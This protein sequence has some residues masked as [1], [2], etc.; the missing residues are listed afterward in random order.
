[1]G[2]PR[3]YFVHTFGCR[4]NQADSAQ[5][6]AALD[7][8]AMERTTS[9]HDADV[10]VLNTCT[11]THR[12]DADVRKAVNRIRRENPAAKVIVT[13]CYAQRDPEG[14]AALSGVS[15]VIGN[16]HR[17][18][19]PVVASALV[20]PGPAGAPVVIH[21]PMDGVDPAELPTVEPVT[22]VLDRTRP[23]V[24]IQDGCDAC[25]TY[26]IIPAVR[27]RARSAT[28][29]DVLRAVES[30]VAQGYV[31]IVLAGVHLGTYGQ[32]MEPPVGLEAL[33]Q[34][35]LQVE[36]LV[37]LRLSCIEPMAFPV[38][39]AELAAA[40]PR[41]APH[42]HLPLQSGS[43]RVLKRMVRPYRAQEFAALVSRIRA[44]VPGACIGTD[45]I[46]GFPGEDDEAF[47][48]TCAFVEE[49]SGLD[50][51]HVFSYSDRDGVPATRLGP[52][53]DPRIIKARSGALHEVSARLWTRYLDA[54][55]GQVRPGV[56]LEREGGVPGRVEVLTDNYVP[57]EV[58][59]QG[60]L[61]NR[62]VRVRITARD[63]HRAR[64]E[65][66]SLPA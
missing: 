15:A 55:V 3:R 60:L 4:V 53:V 42:F 58:D 49:A 32:A 48:E 6:A 59:A 38:A 23:F 64:G 31:E 37:R 44:H 5:V 25:C 56:S 27:G 24:K 14:A 41:L 28:P 29:Q 51:V 13:G 65:L 8:E 50:Y 34:Q 12:S 40:D 20:A 46:V 18:R 19:L 52:K 21:T 39:L 35:V 9:H 62:D 33:V 2:A 63:G 22:T 43:D 1:V 45:V 7:G 36:G 66:Q 30:L 11:V 16:A 47:A 10:V 17:S 61:P 57:V 54:Q 26:C